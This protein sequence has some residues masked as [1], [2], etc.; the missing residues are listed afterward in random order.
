MGSTGVSKEVMGHNFTAFAPEDVDDAKRGEP[1]F[2]L[3]D[4]ATRRRLECVGPTIV[5]ACATVSPPWPDSS[6]KPVPSAFPG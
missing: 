6:S 5:D 4:W 2:D 3:T 1:S